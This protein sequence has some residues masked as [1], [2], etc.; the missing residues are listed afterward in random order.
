MHLKACD[1][2]PESNQCTDCRALES[3]LHLKP[4]RGWLIHM[5]RICEQLQHS[6]SQEYRYWCSTDVVVTHTDQAMSQPLQA[7]F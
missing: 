7:H 4:T 2:T 5:I 3:S 1:V 6:D